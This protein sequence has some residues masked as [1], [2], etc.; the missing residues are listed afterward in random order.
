MPYFN[1]LQG[2]KSGK[3]VGEKLRTKMDCLEIG[4][5][6]YITEGTDHNPWNTTVL[7]EVNGVKTFFNHCFKSNF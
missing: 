2:A 1:S 3:S 6:S 7:K 4:N 5:S